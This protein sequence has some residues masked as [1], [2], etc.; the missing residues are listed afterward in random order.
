MDVGIL[1]GGQ[2]GRMLAL[3]AAPL[4]VTCRFLDPTPDACAG[5]VGPLHTVPWDDL[6][7]VRAFAA[8]VDVVTYE[9]ENVPPETL[10]AA[11][12]VVRVAPGPRALAT[13]CDRRLEKAAFEAVGLAVPPYRAVAEAAEIAPALEH[14]GLPAMLK[15]RTGGYDGK[16]QVRVDAPQDATDGLVTIGRPCL[17]ETRVPFDAE[18]SIAVVRAGDGDVRVWP[19][20]ANSH[21]HGVLAVTRTDRLPIGGDVLRDATAGVIALAESLEYVGVLAVEFFVVDGRLL[22]NEMA[23]RVHNSFHWTMDWA[24]TGQFENHI[25]AVCGW[26]LGATD[27]L[28][29]AA[30]VNQFGTPI[31][32]AVLPA[33]GRHRLHQYGKTSRAGRKVGHVNVRADDS[34][35]LDAAIGQVQR[36]GREAVAA[37]SASAESA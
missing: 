21:D 29:Y 27:G 28:P 9:F 20:S 17:L 32:P 10:A 24:A 8:S 3:A 5:Q 36:L 12:E 13:A 4:G 2:L 6:D 23:A 7:A 1:G 18:V 31:G 30:M 33:D 11:A 37:W 14:V 34:A 26:P 22:A 25:R 35:S 16:G 19:V 15:A